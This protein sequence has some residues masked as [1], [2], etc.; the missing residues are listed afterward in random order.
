MNEAGC[1]VS[2][3]S[4][5]EASQARF[6]TIMSFMAGEKAFT[7]QEDRAYYAPVSIPGQPELGAGIGLA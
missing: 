7:R 6:E 5:F 2:P 3:M 4:F 1:H